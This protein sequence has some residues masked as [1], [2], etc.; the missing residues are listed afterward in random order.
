MERIAQATRYK[1]VTGP[2]NKTLAR[3]PFFHVADLCLP[4][5]I[6]SPGDK[7]GDVH[8]RQRKEKLPR[9]IPAID[10]KE[11]RNAEEYGEG[12]RN[13]LMKKQGIMYAEVDTEERKEAL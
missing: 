10:V 6:R 9:T 2:K 3:L 8:R 4:K 11:N 13:E 1:G 12:T 5:Q 7:S